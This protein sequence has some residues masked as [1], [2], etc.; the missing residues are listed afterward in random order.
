MKTEVIMERELFG[1]EISQKSK[2]EF[3]SAT[4]LVK[5]GNKYRAL[6]HMSLFNFQGWVNSKQTKEFI[7]A[8]E[9]KFGTV[10]IA[11]KGRGVHT[12]V[13]PYLFIDLALAIDPKLKIEVYGWLYD[14]LIRYRND[15]G[16]SYK[17]MAGYLYENM[18]N[19]RDFQTN[20]VKLAQIIQNEVGCNDW[21]KATQMQLEHRDKIHEYITLLCGVFNKNNK[22]AIRQGLVMA[23]KYITE[24]HKA[25]EPER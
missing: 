11:G 15:S 3:F 13:H 12:W 20:M 18:P 4:D 10:Y 9:S 23:K 8:L 25:D 7:E 1:E 5:A 16:D 21:Q 17:K 22:E 19:K 24:K 14:Y 2:N 6:N